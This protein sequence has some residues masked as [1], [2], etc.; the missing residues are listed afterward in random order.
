MRGEEAARLQVI[1]EASRSPIVDTGANGMRRCCAACVELVHR[2]LAAHSC[3]KSLSASQF[4]PRR[5]AVRRTARCSA[6]SG[7]P[8]MLDELPATG[9]PRRSRGRS[10]R[11]GTRGSRAAGSA[12][13]PRREATRPMYGQYSKVSS[14]IAAS[15]SWI[16]TSTCWPRPLA[17]PR[18]QRAE[19]RR[20]RRSARPGTRPAGRTA[21]SGGSSG[22]AGSPF[23]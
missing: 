7:L 11:R 13:A 16:E 22:C 4:A 18:E 5:E 9:A 19:R 15:D 8:I 17:Q 3:R 6:H 14:R 10:S 1:G 12:C 21:L 20:W 2:L 23:R